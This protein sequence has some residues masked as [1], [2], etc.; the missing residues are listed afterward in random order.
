MNL[1]GTYT[2]HINGYDWGCCSDSVWI[3]FDDVIDSVKKED[4]TV[5]ETRE[6]TD[7]SSL[8]FPI[9]IAD[10]NRDIKDIYLIDEF[11]KPADGP[12][13][14]MRI[15]LEV[16]PNDGSVLCFNM[17]TQYN[18]WADP[19]QLHFSLNHPLYSN[20]KEVDA[21]DVLD[22]GSRRSIIDEYPIRQF[23]ASDGTVYQ[24]L[25]Y[26]PDTPCETLVVWL[27]G[28]GEGGN[29]TV[30]NTDVRISALAN[31]VTALFGD[32]FQNTMRKAHVLVIQCPTYWMDDDGRQTN[33]HHGKIKADGSSYYEKSLVECIDWYAKSIGAKKIILS[34]C[35]NGGYM[36]VVLG[37][38][39]PGKWAGLV[40]ICEAVPDA[41]I[42]DEQIQN[43]ADTPIYFIYSKDDPIVDP[44][45]HEIPTIERIRKMNPVDLKISTTEHVVDET[46]LYANPDGTKPYLYSG[47]WSWIYF[48][49]NSSR[50]DATGI[51][52]WDWMASL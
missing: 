43:L 16:S 19:Y 6:T 17:H 25:N 11:G 1:N 15:D 24:Y 14:F 47:H 44:K 28:L 34:G 36:T 38:K 18:T 8:A 20:K 31:K 13:R 51:P 12:S 42:T 50:D 52:V 29:V 9:V 33:F 23:T 4:I 32:S 48:D 27:H 37:M 22:S 21:I 7:W 40:P 30:K 10:F 41:Y 5:T 35:S 3:C 39:Y 2:I 49:N 46:G 45:I 26:V